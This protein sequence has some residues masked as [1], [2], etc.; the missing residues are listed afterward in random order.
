MWPLINKKLRVVGRT[1]GERGGAGAG[2]SASPG[3]A[4][5]GVGGIDLA[6]MPSWW[7]GVVDRT[8]AATKATAVAGSAGGGSDDDNL[9]HDDAAGASIREGR[10]STASRGAK[11]AAPLENPILE[12]G[13]VV[14]TAA[15]AAKTRRGDGG[16]GSLNNSGGPRVPETVG[17]PP[18]M[19]EADDDDD[20]GVQITRWTPPPLSASIAAATTRAEGVARDRQTPAAG[21]A[22]EEIVIEID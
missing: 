7:Q 6:A 1:L 15:A 4:E 21:N 10:L 9:N 5:G 8:A 16:R 17:I 14:G 20:E 2:P 18:A 11:R 19:K 13:S 12:D 3:A 22:G